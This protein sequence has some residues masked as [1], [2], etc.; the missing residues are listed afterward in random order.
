MW[1]NILLNDFSRGLKFMKRGVYHVDHRV[2]HVI[3]VI[4]IN[5]EII[6]AE[7]LLDA[8]LDIVVHL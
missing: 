6:S 3:H 5:L 1:A 2:D 4:S 8:V 7:T